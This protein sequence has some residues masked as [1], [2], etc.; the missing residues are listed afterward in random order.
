MPVLIQSY[1]EKNPVEKEFMMHEL[2]KEVF[3][4]WGVEKLGPVTKLFFDYDCDVEGKDK[5][6]IHQERKEIRD[7]L[8]EHSIHYTNGFVFTEAVQPNKISFHIVF[9]RIAITRDGFHPEL[10]K[11]L[12]C[13]IFGEDRIKNIDEKVYQKKLWFRLPYG[14]L[15]NKPYSHIPYAGAMSDFVVTLHQDTQTKTYEHH[16]YVINKQYEQLM[17]EFQYAGVEDEEPDLSARQ[18]RIIECLETLKPERF[19]EHKEWFQLL[20]LCRG[21][22]VPQHIF[23]DLSQASGYK[24]F[25]RE[26]CIKQWESIQ[27][28]KTFGFPLLHRWME[29]D[30]ID[31]KAMFPTL[32]PIVRAIKNLE[33][34][35]FGS[36][37][38]GIAGVLKKFYDGNLYYTSSHGWIHWTGKKWEMGNDNQVF[39]PICKMLTS[40]LFLYIK[41]QMEKKEARI[42]KLKSLPKE[43]QQ[44]F[45]ISAAELSFVQ[46]KEA[47]KRYRSIQSVAMM[48]S[49]LQ[50]SISLFKDDDILSTFDSIPNLFSF[51]DVSIN[52]QTGEVIPITKEQRILTTCGYKMP[53]R[54][55]TNIEK[56]KALLVEIIGTEYD[57]FV[58]NLSIV[59][60]GGNMNECFV[61]WTGRGRNGK[62][63]VDNIVERV[64]GTYYKTLPI[65]ELTEDSK[66]QGRTSSEVANLR[67]A[68][69][70][71]STEP[72]KGVKLKTGK[73][74]QLTGNDPIDARQLFK[75]AFSYRPKFTLFLQCNEIP[76]FSKLD[77]AIQKRMLIQEFPFQFVYKVER[78]YQRPIDETLKVKIKQDD[79]YRNGLFF[80]LLD[81]YIKHQGK[82]IRT[83]ANEEKQNEV[84]E[85][86][87]PL[88]PFIDE[89][90]ERSVTFIHFKDLFDYYKANVDTSI[91]KS[92]FKDYLLELKS[93]K[94]EEDKSNGMKVFLKR[95]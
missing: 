22:G 10:E 11:E 91:K 95:K 60:Y 13:T 62:G 65:S 88:T 25:N 74:K 5:A 76:K 81:A 54:N 47:F 19:A 75:E 1:Y 36:T 49:I 3:E 29:E 64:L 73:I 55:E 70:V 32:S 45:L 28:K 50:M 30:G 12:L 61:V 57:A 89:Y 83:E 93:I 56:V 84:V 35:D 68:R 16:P 58:Q 94:T 33:Q 42:N 48:K 31:W 21:N 92:V 6:W 23:L 38:F 15:P 52:I 63:V 86:N 80:I 8:I 27:P 72:D 79:S 90:Y 71:V 34:N 41:V 17:R 39:Y 78:D 87:S 24:K 26:G 9:K 18:E 43:Q 59:L 77:D 7:R 20:C 40:E 53:T 2:S 4:V 44:A 37:D 14:T 66:G 82:I 69:Y 46:S 67:W 85:D 51:D